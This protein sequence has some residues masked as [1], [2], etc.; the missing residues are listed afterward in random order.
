MR[1]SYN[2][3]LGFLFMFLP[4]SDRRVEESARNLTFV[5]IEYN[6]STIFTSFCH[7]NLSFLTNL[8]GFYEVYKAKAMLINQ[9]HF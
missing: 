6:F 3:E 4:K 5:K 7:A 1:D 2:K 9:F 8:I